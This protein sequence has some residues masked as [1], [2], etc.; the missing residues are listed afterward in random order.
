MLSWVWQQGRLARWVNRQIG[1]KA[2]K[3]TVKQTAKTAK[4]QNNG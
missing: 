4:E 3:Q 1:S 2:D